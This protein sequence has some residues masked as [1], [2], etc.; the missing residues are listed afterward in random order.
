MV[1]VIY[2][3]C[4][5]HFRRRNLDIQFCDP[6]SCSRPN[7]HFL[8]RASLCDASNGVSHDDPLAISRPSTSLLSIA[9]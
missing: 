3:D 2:G 7:L 4:S 6:V 1:F 5:I 9:L 8:A